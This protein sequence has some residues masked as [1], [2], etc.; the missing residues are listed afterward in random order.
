MNWLQ[1]ILLFIGVSIA[2]VFAFNANEIAIEKNSTQNSSTNF[3]DYSIH[4]YAFIQ[5]QTSINLVLNFKTTDFSIAKW[6]ENYLVELPDYKTIKSV[7][8]F[9]FQDINRCETFSQQLF[10]FHFFW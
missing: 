3:S 8:S 4:S 1:K 2:L 9:L 6:F 10:P 7:N 5:P